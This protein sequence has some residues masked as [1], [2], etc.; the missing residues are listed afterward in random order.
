MM[1]RFMGDR[2]VVEF[3][4]EYINGRYVP[5]KF[6]FDGKLLFEGTDFRPSPMF[7]EVSREAAVGLL[8]FLT[9][10]PGDT[11]DE[12]FDKYTEEQLSWANSRECEELS[13][14][15][16]EEEEALAAKRRG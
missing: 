1:H 6:T 7:D 5:Y 12:Y 4:A 13:G 15:V 14:D 16:Q 9:L 10:R 3:G 2:A 11:D 8:G